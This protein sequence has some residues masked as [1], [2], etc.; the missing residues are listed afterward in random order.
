[1]VRRRPMCKKT[2]LMTHVAYTPAA[3][4]STGRSHSP[5]VVFQLLLTHCFVELLLLSLF[6]LVDYLACCVLTTAQSTMYVSVCI[7]SV[8]VSNFL[9]F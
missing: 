4:Q 6:I 1:M 5:R 7:L 3:M 9:P 8:R 2:S